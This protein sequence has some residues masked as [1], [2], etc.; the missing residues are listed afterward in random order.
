[1]LL[2]LCSLH[3]LL[4]LLRGQ[5]FHGLVNS[6]QADLMAAIERSDAAVTANGDTPAA[7]A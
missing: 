3:I 1:V 5:E 6:T 4:L 2:A 7:Q